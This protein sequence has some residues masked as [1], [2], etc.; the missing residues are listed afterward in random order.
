MVFP[1]Y[2]IDTTSWSSI[3][4]KSIQ[5]ARSTNLDVPISQERMRN[6]P[7]GSRS[8][9]DW[10]RRF[11]RHGKTRHLLEERIHLYAND[12]RSTDAI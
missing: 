7:S 1:S 11:F 5:M 6:L 3:S 2:I 10:A 4:E 12:M 8:S 9:I